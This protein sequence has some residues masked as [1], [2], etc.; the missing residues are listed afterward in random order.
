MKAKY[1][2]FEFVIE[3]DNPDVGVFLYVYQD[4]K[5]VRDFLQNDK[6]TCTEIAF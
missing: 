6:A 5:C 2:D 4:G 1:K 3:E